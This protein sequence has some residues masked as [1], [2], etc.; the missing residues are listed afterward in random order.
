LRP[1]SDELIRKLEAID[2]PQGIVRA[3]QL[4]VLDD[5]RYIVIREM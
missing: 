3:G 1:A 5:I 4:R 2:V